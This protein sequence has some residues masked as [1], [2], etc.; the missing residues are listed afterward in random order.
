M[1]EDYRRGT[2]RHAGD[3]R[4]PVRVVL[5]TGSSGMLGHHVVRE[6]QDHPS[7]QE[8]RLFDVRPFENTLGHPMVKKTRQVVASVCDA[9][10][11]KE[12]VRGA[13]AVIHCAA[14]LPTA[15]LEHE[16]AFEKVNVKGTQNVVEACL[17]ESVPY[18]VCTGSVG[19]IKDEESS[20]DKFLHEGPYSK[21]KA[22][23]ERLVCEAS[24]RLLKD[25]RHRLRTFVARLLA[26]YGE[27]DHVFIAS[28]IKWSKKTFNTLF[29]FGPGHQCIYV[30][31]AA[32]FLVRALNALSEDATLSG[33][34]LVACDDT[35]LDGADLMGPL[36]EGHGIRIYRR[37]IPYPLMMAAALCT[38]GVVKVLAPVFPNVRK[39]MLPKPSDVRYVYRRAVFD[40]TEA[41]DVL[42]WRPKYGQ[43]QVV[44]LSRS[45]YDKL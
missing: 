42:S 9:E 23:A 2:A 36:V 41:R 19:A 13:D 34:C 22:Q 32:A 17:E 11:L 27:L 44:Q 45:F 40:D 31:N 12:A 21:T 24:G 1:D 7:V 10:A 15:V 35:P 6:L 38:L 8:V 4:W 16:A 14:I 33:R 5:V 28:H 18:L 3:V 39:L 25:G 30:G 29:R 43:Q 20:G 26:L 37:P